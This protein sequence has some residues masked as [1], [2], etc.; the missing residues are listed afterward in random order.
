MGQ[1]IKNEKVH[2]NW[3]SYETYNRNNKDGFYILF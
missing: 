3:L 1:N 2:N